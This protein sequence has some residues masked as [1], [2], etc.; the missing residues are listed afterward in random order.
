[1]KK[2]AAIGCGLFGCFCCLLSLPGRALRYAVAAS[3]G[4]NCVSIFAEALKKSC[5]DWLKR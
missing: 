5:S 2:A 1:M 3:I 4:A